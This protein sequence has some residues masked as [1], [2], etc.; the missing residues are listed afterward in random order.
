MHEEDSC[1][2]R[3]YG[4]SRARNPK[5]RD[6]MKNFWWQRLSSKLFG[7]KWVYANRGYEGVIAARVLD[8]DDGLEAVVLNTHLL[9]LGPDNELLWPGSRLEVGKQYWRSL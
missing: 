1:V 7:T 9:I 8:L 2:K 6:E 5:W 3:E 4:Y